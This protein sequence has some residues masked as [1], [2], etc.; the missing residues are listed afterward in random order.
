MDLL[1]NV[2]RFLTTT[3]S[4]INVSSHTKCVFVSN[5]KS[6]TQ[7]TFISLHPNEHTQ[8]LCYYPLAIIMIDRCVW[9]CNALNGL[10]NKLCVPHK[11]EDLN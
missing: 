7:H 9:S 11:T 8:R 3:T 5:E 10:S 6:T 1:K 2:F 4:E